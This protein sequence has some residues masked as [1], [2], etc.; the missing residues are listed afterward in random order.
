[1]DQ[2]CQMTPSRS[3]LPGS[4]PPCQIA[5]K[6]PLSIACVPYTISTMSPAQ[7][8]TIPLALVVPSAN[9]LFSTHLLSYFAVE[10]T[11]Q[12]YLA[13]DLDMFFRYIFLPTLRAF[14]MC[15]GF[16][17][18]TF[19]LVWSARDLNSSQ[20]TEVRDLVLSSFNIA[21]TNLFF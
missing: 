15:I 1:M 12:A 2:N 13:P 17:P 10:F 4:V 20:S 6:Q 16:F 3:Y 5:V 19:H 11:P 9:V 18:E 7:Q 8:R 21:V 14:L